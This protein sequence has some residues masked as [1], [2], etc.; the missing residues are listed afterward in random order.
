VKVFPHLDAWVSSVEHAIPHSEGLKFVTRY[1]IPQ[2][3]YV[4]KPYMIS[5]IGAIQESLTSHCIHYVAHI[6][7]QKIIL[8]SS[9]IWSRVNMKK[10]K[11]HLYRD[12]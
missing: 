8:L 11:R 10:N 7:I 9:V 3:K 4:K 5:W 12:D 1:V 2:N 6:A